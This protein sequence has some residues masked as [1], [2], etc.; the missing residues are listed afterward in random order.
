MQPLAALHDID[1]LFV[2]AIVKEE[3]NF[4]PHARKGEAKGLMQIK[5]RSWR[6]AS[7]LPYESMVWSWRTNLAVGIEDLSSIKKIL[8]EKGVFSYPMLWASY[9][10]GI[11]FTTE[12]GFDTSRMPRPSDPV[13]NKLWSGE[14]HPLPSPK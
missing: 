4:D 5:P 14:P 9:H 11:D 13:S 7:R 12:H 1:P 2:Y 10:Y 6:A 3:S 8:I